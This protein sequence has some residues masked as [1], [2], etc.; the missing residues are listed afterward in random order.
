[1]INI[2]HQSRLK[3]QQKF[4]GSKRDILATLVETVFKVIKVQG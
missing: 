2:K 4:S 3:V 1:M